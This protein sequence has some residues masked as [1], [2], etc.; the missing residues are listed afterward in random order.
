MT[1]MKATFIELTAFTD[2]VS[3]FLPDEA[4]SQLQLELMADPNKGDV[5]PGCGGLRK[6]RASDPARGRGKRGGVRVIYLYI[7]EARWFFLLS[8]YGKGR[9]DDLSNA[10]KKQLAAMATTLQQQAR[11][12]VSWRKKS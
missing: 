5:I 9:K 10:Q 1:G 3:D 7:P 2:W 4:L 6:V 11:D 8:V 12:S